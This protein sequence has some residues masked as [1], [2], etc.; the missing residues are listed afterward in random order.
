VQRFAN[1]PVRRNYTNTKLSAL[2]NPTPNY[3]HTKQFIGTTSSCGCASTDGIELPTF[4]PTDKQLTKHTEQS[5]LPTRTL[6]LLNWAILSNANEI[7]NLSGDASVVSRDQH[8]SGDAS[9]A[10]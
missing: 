3:Q 4:C 7:S 5:S 10:K 6:E 2:L 1:P 9:Q 8:L